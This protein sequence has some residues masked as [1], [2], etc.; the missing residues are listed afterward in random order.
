MKPPAQ[1]P[2]LPRDLVAP[3]PAI[4][5]LFG[6]IDIYLFDQLAR[7]RFDRRYRVVDVGC[8][9]GR[10]LHYLLAHG[11]DCYGIDRDATAI[12]RL[13]HHAH[14]IGVTDAD[15]RF[16]TGDADAL[17]WREQSFDAVICS[18]V[19]H[20]ADDL[21]HFGRMVT[22]M[23]RVLTVDGLFFARL[24][25]TI[26]LAGFAGVAGQRVR[27]PDGSDRFVVDEPLLLEWT[28]RLGGSLADP[29]KTTNVQQMRCM[30][31]W[32]LIK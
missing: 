10:N 16:V 19:L 17:P 24:A 32:C 7:G 1:K 21:D 2:P 4:Q 14:A 25:S 11:H 28:R 23:W 3:G 18:A 26:G 31:T 22:E 27:L 15:T 5:Q 8:G 9:A 6:D 13:R 20:F 12:A 30:T 29:I